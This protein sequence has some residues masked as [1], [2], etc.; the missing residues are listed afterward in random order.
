MLDMRRREFI[1]LL[2]G[3]AA[4]GARAAAGDAGDRIPQRNRSMLCTRRL[5][6]RSGSRWAASPKKIRY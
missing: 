1:T 5:N 4:C 2:G 6:S 3:V